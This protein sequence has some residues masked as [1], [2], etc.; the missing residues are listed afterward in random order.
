MPGSRSTS[1]GQFKFDL[2]RRELSRDGVVVRAGGR[3]L[4]VL[5]VLVSAKGDIVSKAEIMR[6]VWPGQIVDE[7]NLQVHVSSLRKVLGNDRNGQSPLITVPSRGYRLIGVVE[8][9]LA[10]RAERPL[11]AVL[12]FENLGGNAG[13]D[14]FA[15]GIVEEII[16]A[17]SRTRWLLVI[18]RNTSF[19]Y[20]GRAVDV[21]QIGRELGLQYVLEGSVRKSRRRMRISTQL[22]DAESGAH[23]WAET[24]EGTVD[25]IFDFQDHITARIINAIEPH[26][27]DAEIR[28]T[29]RRRPESPNAYDYYLRGMAQFAI[30]TAEG[31]SEAL[32]LLSMAIDRD[33]SFAPPYALAAWCR[34]YRILQSWCDDQAREMDEAAHLARSAIE[35]DRE[36]PT[37]LALAGHAISFATLDHDKSLA[38]IE[39]SL[40]INPNSAVASHAAGW[41]RAYVGDAAGAVECFTRAL[42]M[43]PLDSRIHMFHSGLAFG[44][45]M[46]GQF[47]EAIA[48]ARKCVDNRPHFVFG[49]K[50][51]AAALAN[52]GRLAEASE[53]ATRVMNSDPLFRLR[54]T[55]RLVRPSP[56]R[57][58]YLAGIRKAGIPD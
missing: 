43:S 15:D 9:T 57:D 27:R 58:R 42:R 36:D 55:E 4:D 14:Y 46:L 30:E 24:F 40:A 12:P 22:A 31:S 52:A 23:V 10:Q 49:Y 37:V 48:W 35:L 34:I 7:N 51:L 56:G 17:L 11:I 25:D 54:Q 53:A 18:A 44:N 2:P 3:A 41:V 5:A 19:T 26:L 6:R 32:R 21:K 38:L 50:V 28:R 20:K 39:R 29:Q 47:D 8:T 33:P 45:I 16:T 13:Q 1:F